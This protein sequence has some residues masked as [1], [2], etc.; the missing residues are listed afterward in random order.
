MQVLKFGGT[1]VASADKFLQVA[2]IIEDHS[3][4]GPVAIVLSAPAKIT[5]HLVAMIDKTLLGQDALTHMID[6]ENIF[7]S[8]LSDLSNSLP[9]IDPVSLKGLVDL[10][11]A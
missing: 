9:N 7:S 11:F 10:Q 2:D 6:A 8:I 3:K 5:N 4:Q 1:S